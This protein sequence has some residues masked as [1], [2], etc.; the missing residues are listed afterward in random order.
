MRPS[1][2]SLQQDPQS[3]SQCSLRVPHELWSFV[4][5]TGND[6]MLEVVQFLG[7]SQKESAGSRLPC[8]SS[9]PTELSSHRALTMPPPFLMFSHSCSLQLSHSLCSNSYHS[10]LMSKMLNPAIGHWSPL[11]ILPAQSRDVSCLSEEKSE[12]CCAGMLTSTPRIL[13]SSCLVAREKGEAL[14]SFCAFFCRWMV[15][16]TL[17]QKNKHEQRGKKMYYDLYHPSC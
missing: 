6:C 5:P 3:Q 12:W 8:L 13:S 1:H 9:S 16:A 10:W 4:K 11:P 14:R 17:E 2:P 15:W 7:L